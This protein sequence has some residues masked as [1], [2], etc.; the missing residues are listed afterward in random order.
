D[1]DCRLVPSGD[2]DRSVEVFE[3]DPAARLQRIVVVEVG[4]ILRIAAD[5]FPIAAGQQEKA[6]AEEQLSHVSPLEGNT[7]EAGAE[8]QNQSR[9]T[10]RMRLRLTVKVRSSGGAF[11]SG[12][13]ETSM[14][15]SPASGRSASKMNRPARSS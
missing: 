13:A 2:L 15:Y 10:R 8:F 5:I 14:V 1:I 9:G 12:E 3:R 7:N 6:G 4:G 11:H